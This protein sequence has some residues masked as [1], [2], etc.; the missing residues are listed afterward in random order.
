MPGKEYSRIQESVATNRRHP[1]VM[2]VW[3]DDGVH[4][5][6]RQTIIKE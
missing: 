2:I 5:S 4:A 6:S 3:R 1:L